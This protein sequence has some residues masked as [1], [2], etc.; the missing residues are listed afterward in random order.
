MKRFIR[1]FSA[2]S[3]AGTVLCEERKIPVCKLADVQEGNL[4]EIGIGSK[5]FLICKV[6]GRI[7]C[8][9]AKC[10]HEAGSLTSG[11]LNGF[12]IVC[13][14]HGAEFDVRTGQLVSPPGL[15]SISSYEVSE[16][17]GMVVVNLEKTMEKYQQGQKPDPRHFVIIGA[18]AAGATA[19]ETLRK[20]G[21][22]GKITILSNENLL[23]YDRV[24]LS[25]N[26]FLTRKDL[27]FRKKEHYSENKIEILDNT[28][29]TQVTRNL[30]KTSDGQEFLY[31][32]LLIATGAS[33][34]IPNEFG[35]YLGT[36]NFLSLRNFEDY[37]K[38]KMQVEK[39]KKI[40]I[41]GNRFLGLECAA[42]ISKQFPEVEVSFI[43]Y[44]PQAL[45]K[46]IGPILYSHVFASHKASGIKTIFGSKFRKFV[47]EHNKIT[48]VVLDQG[49]IETDLV[50]I[51]V[52]SSIKT[53]FLPSDLKNT[54]ETVPVNS[55]MQ[56]RYENVYAAGDIAEFQCNLT[57]TNERIE[58]WAV[59][60]QQGKAAAL[61]MLEKQK[62]YE[63]IPYFWSE[64][65]D[66]L[67]MAGFVNNHDEW[68]D[69][70]IDENCKISFFF[71]QNQCIGVAAVNAPG[72]ILKLKVALTRK[73]MPLYSD[74]MAKSIT[75]SD[76]ISSLNLCC[77]NK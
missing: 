36:E 35:Q 34:K 49:P 72:V 18:G 8:V 54:D 52:G 57:G 64:Q 25:K 65:F 11:F 69:E 27:E 1:L 17:D 23:P 19:A 60:Q 4:K 21:F 62:A 5:R 32:K 50:L 53:P 66:Y 29:V 70:I 77:S 2:F 63:D 20:E 43:E 76:I 59:A 55:F 40:C 10:P 7:Y 61:N 31:D 48:S 33:P 71:K 24:L 74:F 9:S 38:L 75:S 14:L 44:D 28:T 26:F 30:V 51:S 68:I 13:P 3:V 6:L 45:G 39:A 37:E 67:E 16:K 12:H 42:S 47:I 15:K 22:T 41:I 46:V 73:T 58:H 56:T